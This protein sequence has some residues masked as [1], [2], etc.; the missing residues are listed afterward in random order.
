MSGPVSF[1]PFNARPSVVSHLSRMMGS[2]QHLALG[3]VLK[4]HALHISIAATRAVPPTIERVVK[5]FQDRLES[6]ILRWPVTD[7]PEQTCQL[8][9]SGGRW[10]FQTTIEG[11]LQRQFLD[12]GRMT[13]MGRK[14]SSV[15]GLA[16]TQAAI[17]GFTLS[18][19]NFDVAHNGVAFR[20]NYLEHQ[21]QMVG[22][23]CNVWH[24][25]QFSMTLP[26]PS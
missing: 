6:C 3:N 18:D 5:E 10:T 16:A 4:F 8:S 14:W 21:Q 19:Y 25:V 20:G 9:W 7:S 17:N 12:T 2:L 26:F 24:S 11:S 1:H 23:P 13:Y 15:F 22:N